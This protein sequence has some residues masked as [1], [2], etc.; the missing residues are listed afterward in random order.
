MRPTSEFAPLLCICGASLAPLAVKPGV[1]R[2]GESSEQLTR[3]A[4]ACPI[5]HF[6]SEPQAH[7]HPTPKTTLISDSDPLGASSRTAVDEPAGRYHAT[8]CVGVFR[9][10]KQKRSSHTVAGDGP[11][12][13]VHR[14][15]TV[16]LP[17]TLP[18]SAVGQK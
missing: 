4:V 14:K 10:Q 16:E 12:S 13:P 3:R 7:S 11:R 17:G 6:E 2:V 5:P 1:A 9:F 15:P 8:A 18:Y